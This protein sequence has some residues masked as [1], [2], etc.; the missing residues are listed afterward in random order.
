MQEIKNLDNLVDIRNISVDPGLS[1]DARIAEYLR[2]IKDPYHYKCA[3]IA[4]TSH[5]PKDGPTIEECLH[6]LLA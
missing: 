5:Y 1:K 6:G 4:I 3:N 2:Q